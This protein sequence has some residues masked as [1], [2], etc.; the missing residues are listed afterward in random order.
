MSLIKLIILII[1]IQLLILKLRPQALILWLKHHSLIILLQTLNFNFLQDLPMHSLLKIF[2]LNLF[3]EL[4]FNHN[5][6]VVN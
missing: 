6:R 2:I 3:N 4:N 1:N 5:F